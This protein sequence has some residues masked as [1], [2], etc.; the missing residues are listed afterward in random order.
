MTAEELM[1]T[2]DL[3]M[4]DL[5]ILK[6]NVYRKKPIDTL[7]TVTRLKTCRSILKPL[8]RE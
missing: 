7:C 3:K 8:T 2:E 1:V 4:T 6:N 5:I